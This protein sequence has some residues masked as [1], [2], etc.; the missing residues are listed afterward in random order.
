MS[1]GTITAASKCLHCEGVS[2]RW[3]VKRVRGSGSLASQCTLIWSCAGC[4]AEVE[5]PLARGGGAGTALPSPRPAA[6]R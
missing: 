4:G 6:P 5:E 2:F 3:R 1:D